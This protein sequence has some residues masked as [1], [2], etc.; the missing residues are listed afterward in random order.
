MTVYELGRMIIYK[1]CGDLL[2]VDESVL[3]WKLSTSVAGRM[4]FMDS[5]WKG[6]ISQMT[7]RM[8]VI[9]LIFFLKQLDL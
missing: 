4:L 1:R 3:L 7:V 6:L 9:S 2:R 8:K 5:G